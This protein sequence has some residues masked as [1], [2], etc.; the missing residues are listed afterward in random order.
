MKFEIPFNEQVYYEQM[1]LNF[2]TA[3]NENLKKNKKMF[4][5]AIFLILFGALINYGKNNIGFLAIAFGIHYLING[6]NYYF[7]YKKSKDVFY[8]LV[9]KEKIGQQKANVNSFWEFNDDHFIYK[10]YKYEAKIKWEAFISSRIIEMNL[11]LDL[12]VGNNSSYVLG[13]TEI[14]IEKFLQV[15][16]FVKNKIGQNKMAQIN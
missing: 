12:N 9:E 11:F 16:E 7:F 3:W 10:D 5:F 6:Y 14:G 2:N 1:T 13:E 4:F 15:S 8:E